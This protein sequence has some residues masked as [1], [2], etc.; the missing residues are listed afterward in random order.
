MMVIPQGCLDCLHMS[1]HEICTLC[2]SCVPE[3]SHHCY[4]ELEFCSDLHTDNDT[5]K[6]CAACHVQH[7]H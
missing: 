6:G 3:L 1:G 2:F 5:S 4:S 7:F